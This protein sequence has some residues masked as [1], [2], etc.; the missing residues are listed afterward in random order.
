MLLERV[1]DARLL[2]LRQRVVAPN[3][4]LQLRELADH[5]SDQ[6]GLGETRGARR[7]LD[8]GADPRREFAR[9]RFDAL[10]PLALRP[11]LLVEDDPERLEPGEALVERLFG[12]VLVVGQ[13]REVGQPEVARVGEPRAHDAPVAGRNRRAAVAGDEI[14]DEDE[15]VGELAVGVLQ[16]EAFLVG[17]D[18]RADHFGGNVEERRLEFAHQH[19]RP[20]DEAGD[21]FEQPLVLDEFEPLREGEAPGVGEDNRLAAIGVEHD[22]GLLQSVRVV[23]ESAHGD[24]RRR[25]EA[26]ARGHIAGRDPVDVELDDLG[27]VMRRS[28]RAEDA[29]QRAYPAQRVRLRRGCAP[30]HRLRP[31]EGA[32]DRGDDFGQRLLGRPAGPF[33]QGNI[34][35]RPSSDPVR[36]TRPRSARG[37]RF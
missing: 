22:L 24:R 27:G 8:V 33:N 15:T 26:M 31:G 14:R 6:I 7:K 36:S 18:R 1:G 3:Q 30:A 32:N 21:L 25:H 34:V 9:Q 20:F 13:R 35:R 19:D 5:F 17:A 29:A 28:E 37:R 11:E 10:D 23:V 4:A 16:H 2:A 12:P